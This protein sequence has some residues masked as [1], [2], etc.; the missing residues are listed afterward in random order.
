MFW[1]KADISRGQ[2]LYYPMEY[3]GEFG[4]PETNTFLKIKS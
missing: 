3:C 2:S 4:M 1:F